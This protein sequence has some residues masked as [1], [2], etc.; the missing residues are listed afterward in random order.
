MTKN[1]SETQVSELTDTSFNSAD[2]KKWSTKLDINHAGLLRK[3][4]IITFFVFGLGGI[5]AVTAPL[6]GAIIASGKVIPSGKN[7]PIQHLEGGIL[8]DTLVE[9]GDFVNAGD[10]LLE[11]DTTSL[12]AQLVAKQLQHAVASIQAARRRAEINELDDVV[13][14]KDFT[15]AIA[16]HP[17]VVEA[18]S[19]QSEEF[20]AGKKFRQASSEI[21]DIR[22]QGRQG[23]IEGRHEVLEALNRQLELFQLEL[24]DFTVLLEQ[25]HIS[26]TRVFATER[27]VVELISSIA[28]NK[29]EVKKAENDILNLQ[30]EKRQKKLE[31]MQQ[32]HKN[33]V[34]LQKTLGSLDSDITRLEDQIVRTVVRAP[35]SGTVFQ[36]GKRT[37]GEVVKSGDTI[38]VLFPNDDSLTIEASLLPTDRDEVFLG[39]DVQVIFPSDKKNR[40]LPVPGKLT[41]VSADT[42]TTQEDDVGSYTIKVEVSSEVS[43]EQFMSGNIADVYIQTGTKT[44]VEIVAEPVTRFAF[45]AFKG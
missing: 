2:L 44:F 28:N 21:I 24:R 32:A 7:R 35:V 23:D 14:P 30:T 6:G 10:V 19:S 40:M 13:F 29:L 33:L 41:Y 36:L 4:A 5:W 43:P 20:H 11:L 16:Q 15:P 8:K 39:Q 1:V 17:R 25:G 3:A 37:I 26:R 31:F 9:E 27:K 22:I 45:N 38:M 42:V 18:L 34:E 12:D